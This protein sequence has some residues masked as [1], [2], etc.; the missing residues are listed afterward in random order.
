MPPPRS[1]TP[2]RAAIGGLLSGKLTRPRIA[3]CSARGRGA[4]PSVVKE[5]ATMTIKSRPIPMLLE[6]VQHLPGR[7]AA[8]RHP[9]GLPPVV[10]Q[11][12]AEF[13]IPCGPESDGAFYAHDRCI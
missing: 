1:L 8:R 6:P 12:S 4:A 9:P 11:S 7:V 13:D 3:P 10:L 5:T 2:G